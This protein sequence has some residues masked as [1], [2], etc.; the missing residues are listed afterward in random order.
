MSA[1][2]A[3]AHQVRVNPFLHCTFHRTKSDPLE[4]AANTIRLETNVNVSG[5]CLVNSELMRH[6]KCLQPEQLTIIHGLLDKL[7]TYMDFAVANTSDTHIIPYTCCSYFK[8]F[9]EAQTVLTKTCVPITGPETVEYVLG[10][11]NTIAAEPIE[12]GCGRYDS[13]RNCKQ[14]LPEAME[15]YERLPV[16]SKGYSIIIPL[17]GL[18]ER[19]D[20]SLVET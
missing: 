20:A 14:N 18:F 9:E 15:V 5:A 10:L 8:V 1:S 7:V 19:L 13:V 6:A 2:H 3:T 17:L 16:V 12:L 11:I 4:A